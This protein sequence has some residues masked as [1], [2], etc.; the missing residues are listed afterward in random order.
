MPARAIDWDA[1]HR[2][3]AVAATAIVHAAN[4]VLKGVLFG[5]MADFKIVLRFG[6]PAIA[7]AYLGAI[8]L[9]H[10]SHLPT[11]FSY[12]LLGLTAQVTPLKLILGIMILGFALFELHPGLQK[13]SFHKKYLPVGGI[14]SGFF[15]GL[16]GHQ[17]ALRSAFLSKVDIT[18]QAFVG[19]NAVIGLLVD[20]T[21]LFVYASV[22][23]SFDPAT[24]TTSPEG[25]VILTGTTAAFLGVLIGRKF[26]HKVT[27][28]TIQYIT[29]IL[30]ML[31]GFVMTAGLI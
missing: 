31:I 18:A 23:V 29:G 30:L 17:G 15:G 6:F 9:A 13:L 12:E 8:V 11:F 14:L 20:L 5:R 4:S 16:S 10:L 25:M 1:I 24:L 19:T 28:K 7:A 22:L 3:L 21:R 26:L 27:M 2:R